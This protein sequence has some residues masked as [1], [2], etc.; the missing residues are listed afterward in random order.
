M[1][2]R[3][4]PALAILLV[5]GLA[6]RAAASDAAGTAE[7]EVSGADFTADE[8]ADRAA[9]TAELGL[10]AEESA[11]SVPP[12]PVTPPPPPCP[13]RDPEN[14]RCYPSADAA[15]LAWLART[16]G[17]A[18]A[19]ADDE[20]PDDGLEAV[21]TPR[22]PGFWRSLG[23][24]IR[25]LV[26]RRSDSRPVAI[27]EEEFPVIENGRVTFERLKLNANPFYVAGASAGAVT[28]ASRSS[29]INVSAGGGSVP[30]FVLD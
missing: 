22:P 4:L 21:E 12:A 8:A 30:T 28:R 11:P 27:P 29:V 25:S 10:E 9:L 2:R 1:L 7:A 15:D 18:L 16:R 23:D 6:P 17:P 3:A 26:V 14:G 5:A 24:R 19:D 13:V 20:D